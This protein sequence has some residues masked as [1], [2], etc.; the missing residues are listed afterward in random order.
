MITTHI[1]CRP[2][3]G[4]T[5]A[6]KEAA[7]TVLD[8]VVPAMF[9]AQQPWALMGSTASVLQGIPDYS[10]PD[11]DLTTTSDGAYAME[12]ALGVCAETVRAVSHSTKGP[13]TSDFGIFDVRGVKVE[14]MGDLVIH[15][16]DGAIDTKDHWARWS[17]KVRVL[18]FERFHIPV[19]PL[20]WQLV[21]NALLGRPE[22]VNGIAEYLCRHGYDRAYLDALLA[23]RGYGERTLNWVRDV[24]GIDD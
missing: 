17:D 16:E 23:D 2:G 3:N 13:Y 20:E 10:P 21:A 5:E 9:K 4:L 19:V 11:I 22:R 7:L 1:D 12:R 6:V 14:I 8:A 24:L 18:H 15:C